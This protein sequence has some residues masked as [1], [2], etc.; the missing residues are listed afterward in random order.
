MKGTLTKTQN[1]WRVNQ[2]L[3]VHPDCLKEQTESAFIWNDSVYRDGDQ[4]EFETRTIYVEPDDSIHCNRGG[5][6]VYAMLETEWSRIFEGFTGGVKQIPPMGN[7]RQMTEYLTENYYP[8][9][10]KAKQ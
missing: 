9:K 8:P 1:G 2:T 10:R 5:D 6:V 4:V 7:Y 3:P